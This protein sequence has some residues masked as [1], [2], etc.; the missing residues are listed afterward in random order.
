MLEC[1]ECKRHMPLWEG[2]LA[3]YNGPYG[4]AALLRDPEGRDRV[5][6]CEHCGAR[7]RY[8]R[9]ALQQISGFALACAWLGCFLV[10]YYHYHERVLS[11]VVLFLGLPSVVIHVLVTTRFEVID[12]SDAYQQRE[13]IGRGIKR[14]CPHC[15]NVIPSEERVC[16]GCGERLYPPLRPT[17][18]DKIAAL[19]QQIDKATLTSSPE[20]YF[21]KAQEHAWNRQVKEAA[22]ELG[23]V[24][25]V[26]KP[27][28][29]IHL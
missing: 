10:F 9:S 2:M 21:T 25:L 29:E 19:L 22:L 5:T 6:R 11:W 12:P 20:E 24:L 7:L 13:A 28:S 18:H 3:F 15:R 1:P 26:S 16:P 17:T 4:W 8:K 23:K 14:V 27:K